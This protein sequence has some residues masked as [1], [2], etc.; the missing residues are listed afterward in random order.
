[1]ITWVIRVILKTWFLV[2]E[3]SLN[4]FN[5]DQITK[6]SKLPFW[7]NS[8]ENYYYSEISG[9][10]ILPQDL[11]MPCEV[12]WKWVRILFFWNILVWNICGLEYSG[13]EIYLVWNILA[14]NI[15]VWNISGLEYSGLE[16][17]WFG[18]FWFGTYLVWNILVW[19]TSVL[20]YSV[21]EYSWYGYL[22]KFQSFKW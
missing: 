12:V 9:G 18:I 8:F 17:I 2:V 11:L 7:R 4:L 20:E 6:A 19:N 14:W 3:I 15:M 16:Y 21:L 1:M 5:M 13:F 10:W 22:T